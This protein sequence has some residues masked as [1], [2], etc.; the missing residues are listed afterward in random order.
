MPLFGSSHKDNSTLQKP[1]HGAAPQAGM[2]GTGAGYGN[3][4]VGAGVAHSNHNPLAPTT[5]TMGVGE[6]AMGNHNMVGGDRHHAGGMHD[7]HGGAGMA[8]T[9]TAHHTGGMTGGAIPA[10]G[11][12]GT[13][14]QQQPHSGAGNHTGG[15]T[16]TGGG[17]PPAG[18]ISSQH[19]QQP[20]SSGGGALTGKIEH[21]VGTIVGSKSLKAK[22]AEKEREAAGLKVQSQELAEAERLEQE[23]GMR[24]ERAVAHGAHP[25][26]RHVGGNVP[27]A[28]VP[29]AYN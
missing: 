14:H 3:A 7:A 16:G 2:D 12:M 24:R 17:I 1:H 18:V 11:A 15:M 29:G 8:G 5:G 27:G 20:H 10:T 28:G 23:A 13:Q 6:P 26:N 19:Q 4:P 25:D 22:G 21:A 9:G